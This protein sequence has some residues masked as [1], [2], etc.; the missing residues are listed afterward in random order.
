MIRKIAES[1]REVFISLSEEFY[2]SPAVLHPVPREYHEAAF[3]ELM[4]SG[5][6]AD[7]FIVEADGK[8]VGLCSHG[9]VLF[10]RVGRKGALAGRI[11]YQ[12]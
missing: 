4:R 7:A 6:Y 11:I 5:E 12:A 10:A 3:D 2:A 8:T 9:K 1:D